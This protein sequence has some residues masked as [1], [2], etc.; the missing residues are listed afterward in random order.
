MD[1]L[2]PALGRLRRRLGVQ[3]WLELCVLALCAGLAL[4]CLSL[5]T[6][7]AI[8]LPVVEWWGLRIMPGAAVL[9]S[10]GLAW[11]RWPSLLSAALEADA[12]LGTKE[13]LTS[14]LQ[15]EHVDGP[16][17]AALHADARA[18]LAGL[19]LP[20]AFPYTAPRTLRYLAAPLVLLGVGYL[21]LPELD[22]LGLHAQQQEAKVRAETRR[23]QAERIKAAAIPLREPAVTPDAVAG[24]T[25]AEIERIAAQVG[26]GELSGKQA[27][28]KLS[29]LAEQLEKQREALQPAAAMPRLAQNLAKLDA[30]REMA[31][32]LMNGKFGEAAAAAR[33]LQEK[34]KKGELGAE[35]RKK[36]AAELKATSEMLMGQEA[37]NSPELSEALADAAAQMMEAAEMDAP[38]D[39]ADAPLALED[40]ASIM[41]QLDKL[42]AAMAQLTECQ[43]A[44]LGESEFC[45][46]CGEKLKK[47]PNGNCG[48]CGPGHSCHGVCGSC[49]GSGWCACTGKGS[50]R[51]GESNKFSNSMGGPG[52]GRGQSTGPLPDVED[53]FSPTILPGKIT[54]G[55]F[56]ADIVQRA[57]P[58][59]TEQPT[60][61]FVTEVVAEA[62]QEAEEALS[63]E[64]IPPGSRELVRQYFSTLD[65]QGQSGA[66]TE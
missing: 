65:S 55:Q 18:H 31:A 9:V 33:Q 43:S 19:H 40:I 46:I 63:K 50:W 64:E 38:A 44:M 32:N 8:G 22:L 21:F 39:A 27:A 26:G 42:N 57:K 12:R 17:V 10:L 25:A 11:R 24:E 6:A 47:C 35:E 49:S 2:R 23:M 7:R 61:Q 34:L 3:Q 59:G 16:M 4:C 53:S 56:L 37:T 30:A 28:A 20:E 52:K 51:A 5:L 41:E 66:A 60:A 54:K 58:E 13:R 48:K 36:L 1:P 15:L 29:N 45:R 62:K 14:S